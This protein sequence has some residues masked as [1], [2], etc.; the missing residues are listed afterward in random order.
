MD[1]TA[2]EHR[3][4]KQIVDLLG[5][6]PDQITLTSNFAEDLAMDSLDRVELV[7]AVEDEFGIEINADDASKFM[8]VGDVIT[9]LGRDDLVKSTR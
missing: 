9:Y 4:Q 6:A 2:I 8:N 3:V 1:T 7:M 5:V